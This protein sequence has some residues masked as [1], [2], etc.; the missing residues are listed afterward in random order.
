MQRRLPAVDYKMMWNA[1]KIWIQLLYWVSL[2]QLCLL[3]WKIAFRERILPPHPVTTREQP[4][5]SDEGNGNTTERSR[6]DEV[7]ALRSS[8]VA[9]RQ[10][11]ANSYRNE[12]MWQLIS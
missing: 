10:L 2:F 6:N 9:R 8:T 1:M 4:A 5:N 3:L 11:P 7:Q 12:M